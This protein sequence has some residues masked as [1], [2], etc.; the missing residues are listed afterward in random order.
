MAKDK[1]INIRMSKE[2]K[3]LLEKDA[4]DQQRSVSNLIL[5]CW[6]Q[7]RKEKKKE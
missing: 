2:E 5:W 6:K 4:K 1:L 7:W 3:K